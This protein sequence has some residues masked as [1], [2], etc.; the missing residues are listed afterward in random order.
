MKDRS[1]R[2]Q[3]VIPKP[4]HLKGQPTSTTDHRPPGRL[5]SDV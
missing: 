4:V 2:L 5:Q 1:R 3:L